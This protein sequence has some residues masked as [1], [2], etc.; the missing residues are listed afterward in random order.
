[1]ILCLVGWE[2]EQDGYGGG[3]RALLSYDDG[4]T[5]DP[6]HDYIVL[7]AQNDSLSAF[8]RSGCGC[9]NG[10]GNTIQLPNGDTYMCIRSARI[11]IVGK[12][13]SCMVSK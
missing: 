3:T 6:A 1:M 12:Y 8:C 4:D 9:H 2:N 7:S 5:F 10:Y 11:K 13:Q